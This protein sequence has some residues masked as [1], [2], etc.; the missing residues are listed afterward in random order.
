M[1]VYFTA[2]LR[3]VQYYERYY[4][5]ISEEI[6]KLGH[7]HLDD[8]IFTL[9]RAKYYSELETTGKES[10]IKLYQKKILAIQTADVCVFEVSLNSLSIG[11]QIEKSLYYHKPTIILY[12]E[13][14]IPYFFDGIDHEK[15]I[16]RS[17]KENSLPSVLKQ[18][19]VD[20]Q[21]KKE[22]RFNFFI[23]PALINYLD[24]SAKKL[25]MT[26]SVYIRTLIEEDMKRRSS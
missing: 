21:H 25:G 15:L 16:L 8:E 7:Q 12:L 11:Y 5:Q 20:A 22:Q 13:D 10:H 24:E 23:S 9:N 14:S 6:V 1:K 2:S 19:F 3:G 26:K 4:K 18:A 17:Y